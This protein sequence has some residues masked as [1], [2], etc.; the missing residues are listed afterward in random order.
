M[1]S[2]RAHK[3]SSPHEWIMIRGSVMRSSGSPSALELADITTS[4]LPSPATLIAPNQWFCATSLNLPPLGAEQIHR[5]T[6]LQRESLFPGYENPLLLDTFST[7]EHSAENSEENTP[8]TIAL[9]LDANSADQLYQNLDE[10][11][12]QL[13][14]ILPRAV[15]LLAGQATGQTAALLD[16]D[17]DSFTLVAWDG[18]T[19]SHWLQMS[20]S[21]M[22]HPTFKAEWNSQVDAM[23][24]QFD[25]FFEISTK[26]AWESAVVAIPSHPLF[27]PPKQIQFNQQ[28]TR[29]KRR[30]GVSILLLLT[31][32]GLSTPFIDALL[33]GLQLRQSL[34]TLQEETRTISETRNHTVRLENE[35]APIL[36]M[37]VADLRAIFLSLNQ[38]IPADTRLTHFKFEKGRIEMEGI[39]P[40]PEQLLIALENHPEY[41]KVALSRAVQGEQQKSDLNR[42]GIQLQLRDYDLQSYLDEFFPEVPQ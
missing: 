22:N 17:E 3:N 26:R 9:W 32:I 15:A 20:R 8:A 1:F 34:S 2:T 33:S 25:L 27:T 7:S 21:D 38:L 41:Q 11:A 35:Y 4:Q 42:F 10:S 24:K 23:R 37:P 19:L 30:K 13:N 36:R 28:R 16:Q 31:A 12:I 14:A 5:A 29:L 40:N 6:L 39:G 18:Q